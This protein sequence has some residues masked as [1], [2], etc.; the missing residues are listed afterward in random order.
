M[1]KITIFIQL[2]DLIVIMST[3]MTRRPLTLPEKLTLAAIPTYF[4]ASLTVGLYIYGSKLGGAPLRSIEWPLIG[5]R[6][7][8]QVPVATL[9]NL[10]YFIV[11]E[12]GDY[13]DCPTCLSFWIQVF[14]SI[15]GF[16][17]S[18]AVALAADAIFSYQVPVSGLF[19]A[20]ALALTPIS[21]FFFLT[22]PLGINSL[23]PPLVP[24]KTSIHRFFIASKAIYILS[25]VSALFGIRPL[26]SWL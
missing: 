14:G 7:L 26:S 17:A 21:L 1:H 13:T 16:F 12:H 25:L 8:L 2:S 3:Q 23:I 15:F 11:V 18:G 24:F 6:L 4:A 19:T 9:W 10:P 20:W 5:P 22:N